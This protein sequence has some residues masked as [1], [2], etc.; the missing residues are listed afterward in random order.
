LKKLDRDSEWY[1]YLL[2][3]ARESFPAAVYQKYLEMAKVLYEKNQ[4]SYLRKA[5]EASYVSFDGN[6]AFHGNTKLSLDKVVDVIRYFAASKK[7]SAL[8]KVKLL[9][10]LCSLS[11]TRLFPPLRKADLLWLRNL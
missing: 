5:I 9:K 10:L 7:V 6:P 4:D 2:N 3:E 1:L 11:Q 8:Y